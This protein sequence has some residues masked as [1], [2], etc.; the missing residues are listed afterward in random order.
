MLIVLSLGIAAVGAILVWFPRLRLG[1]LPGEFSIDLNSG[2]FYFP[3]A[4]SILVSV[5]L[6][7]G[8]DA[9][10]L[11]L[12]EVTVVTGLPWSSVRLPGESGP[13]PFPF[14][15]EAGWTNE[16]TRGNTKRGGG[17]YWTRTSDLRRVK[18]AL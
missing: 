15:G 16:E 4:T 10:E 5:L 17:R 9:G 6:E 11:A 2:R 8:P 1:R 13:F 18:T 3:V 7:P 12:Q 14:S